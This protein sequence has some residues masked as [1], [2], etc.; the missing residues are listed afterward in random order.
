M[1]DVPM[2]AIIRHSSRL[3]VYIVVPGGWTARVPDVWGQQC[4]NDDLRD[5]YADYF[6]SCGMGISAAHRAAEDTV[7]RTYAHGYID[8][9]KEAVARRAEEY[10]A[11]YAEHR[12]TVG[13][14]AGLPLIELRGFNAAAV[15]AA[16]VP[17]QR[18]GR[19]GQ[20]FV[21]DM[22]AAM[23]AAATKGAA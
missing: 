22:L 10:A 7:Q 11:R 18:T 13:R 21:N 23:A 2:P 12:R 16:Y 9:L 6:A 14:R 20:A 4:G 3:G 19:P 15:Q 1:A 8:G 17:F 5:G